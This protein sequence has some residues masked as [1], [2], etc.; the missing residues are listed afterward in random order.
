MPTLVQSAFARTV[1]GTGPGLVLAHGAGGSIEM[2]Y[3]PILDGLAAG[4][5][6]VGV[7]YPG[8]GDT[9]RATR[10]FDVDELADQLVA[11]SDAEGLQTF[12]LAGYSLGGPIAVR[13]AVRHPE[14]VKALILTATFAHRDTK[15]ALLADVWHRLDASGDHE[16]LAKFLNLVAFST[17]ALRALTDEQLQAAVAGL[18]GAITAGTPEQTELVGRIDVRDD[19]ARIAVP[20][21]V[22][23]TTG[24]AVVSPELQ[25]EL[26]D[27]IPGA[28]L[29][30]LDS[31]HLPFVELPEAWLGLITSFL[32]D[33]QL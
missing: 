18:A 12:A 17:P 11:A 30:S 33:H 3:G 21:L 29:V 27:G 4:H 8:T 22:I 2:N 32:A 16:L 9:P 28:R 7:D 23:S 26:A 15:L 1:R 25:K 20:T 31:G 5:T 19:L 14:R 13:A 10:P 6:V 24:D